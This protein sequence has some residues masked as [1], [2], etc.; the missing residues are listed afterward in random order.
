MSC[1]DFTG[2]GQLP[3]CQTKQQF[4]MSGTQTNL[5]LTSPQKSQHYDV[6]S[7][8]FFFNNLFK[9]F[10]VLSLLITNLFDVNFR[11]DQELFAYIIDE[12]IHEPTTV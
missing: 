4:F 12:V 2:P 5:D 9:Q 7:S 3:N 1:D 8:V 11:I 10:V 6:S